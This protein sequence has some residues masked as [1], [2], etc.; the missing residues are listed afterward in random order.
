LLPDLSELTGIVKSRPVVPEIRA[1]QD[2][3]IEK[4]LNSGE[5]VI[6]EGQLRLAPPAAGRRGGAG[7]A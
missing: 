4:D 5:I 7:A 1:D 6:T 3:V 2:L